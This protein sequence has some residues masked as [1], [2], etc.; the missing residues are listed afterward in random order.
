[1]K[2]NK[3]TI[4]IYLVSVYDD[5]LKEVCAGIEEE[6][7]FYEILLDGQ[8]LEFHQALIGA[9]E[10]AVGVGISIVHRVLTL[11]IS[12]QMKTPLFQLKSPTKDSARRLGQNAARYVKR[13]PF[14]EM[15]WG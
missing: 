10:S 5:I 14:L 9:N 2:V 1:M 3:S 12:N 6:G 15:N 4:K 11:C 7:V 8:A 13:L